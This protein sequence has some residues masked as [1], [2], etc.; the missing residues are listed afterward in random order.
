MKNQNYRGGWKSYWF[1][2][3]PITQRPVIAK[4]IRSSSSLGS[5]SSRYG[6][7]SVAPEVASSGTNNNSTKPYI[8]RRDVPN[9]G[10]ASCTSSE[11]YYGW[12]FKPY[13][14]AVKWNV[15]V[16]YL[17]NAQLTIQ[18]PSSSIYCECLRGMSSS[19]MCPCSLD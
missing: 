1:L 17:D 13:E 7:G 6:Y 11:S 16:S 3:M 5:N 15:D 10:A 2:K 12:N 14:P 19:G 9:S 18:L 4:Y 8:K